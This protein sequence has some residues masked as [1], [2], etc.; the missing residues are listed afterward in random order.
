VATGKPP[1][2]IEEETDPTLFQGVWAKIRAGAS[3]EE[4]ES[5]FFVDS[6]RIYR[7]LA[8]WIEEGSLEANAS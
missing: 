5:D 3:P 6:F 4:C 7:L 1:T 2:P 8:H